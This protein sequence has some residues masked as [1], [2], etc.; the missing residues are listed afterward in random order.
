MCPPSS[1][2]RPSNLAR[3][4]CHT[5]HSSDFTWSDTHA[6][7]PA[8]QPWLRRMIL[9]CRSAHK[10]CASSGALQP[11]KGHGGRAGARLL[12]WRLPAPE[13]VSATLAC[14][15]S[16]T[17]WVAVWLLQHGQPSH[18]LPTA[19]HSN[20]TSLTRAMSAQSWSLRSMDETRSAIARP[21]SSN[22]KGRLFSD[23]SVPLRY[24]FRSHEF[25]SSPCTGS[26][27]T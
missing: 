23:S 22:S 16:G 13:A 12:R 9:H 21:L 5:D 19:S 2:K 3:E 6:T 14:S 8:K 10:P 17:A 27:L 11:F 15:G 20:V 18:H 1:T 25:R 26:T 24:L 4:L 7:C